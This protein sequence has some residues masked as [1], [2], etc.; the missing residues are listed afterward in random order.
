METVCL[1]YRG[2]SFQGPVENNDFLCDYYLTD[3][4]VQGDDIIQIWST[5]SFCF[6]F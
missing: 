4:M 6:K 2:R 5:K 3:D 1:Q